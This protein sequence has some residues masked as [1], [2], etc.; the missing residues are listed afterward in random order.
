MHQLGI[1]LPPLPGN[2]ELN[3]RSDF[4]DYLRKWMNLRES[5]RVAPVLAIKALIRQFLNDNQSLLD[6]YQGI[7]HVAVVRPV[8]LDAMEN[9]GK[10]VKCEKT[11]K[12]VVGDAMNSDV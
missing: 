9:I 3:D 11:V 2:V 6:D 5:E 10:M 8:K 4:E 1:T 12:V 7:V